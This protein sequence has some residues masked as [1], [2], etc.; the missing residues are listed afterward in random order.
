[1]YL[2]NSGGGSAQIGKH[3]TLANFEGPCLHVMFIRLILPRVQIQQQR[4]IMEITFFTYF[5]F[6]VRVKYHELVK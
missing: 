1:M 5:N 3:T 4:Y 6:R 2:S